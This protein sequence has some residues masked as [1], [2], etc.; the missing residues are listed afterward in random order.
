MLLSQFY[1]HSP[2][3]CA[4]NWKIRNN[5]L[6]KLIR[7][8]NNIVEGDVYSRCSQMWNYIYKHST[9]YWGIW[10]VE[11]ND[12]QGCRETVCFGTLPTCHLRLACT[13]ENILLS[14]RLQSWG[15]F[16][17]EEEGGTHPALPCHCKESGAQGQARGS[18]AEDQLKAECL[19]KTCSDNLA[20]I[21]VPTGRR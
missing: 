3:C 11:C 18:Q 20:Q 8:H 9:I 1:L 21:L 15:S 13:T 17:R 10:T 12:T 5:S 14:R 6:R 2:A 16:P 7:G 4:S 19:L